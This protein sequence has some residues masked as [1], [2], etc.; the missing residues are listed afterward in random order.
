MDSNEQRDNEKTDYTMKNEDG[1][2]SSIRLDKFVSDIL[3]KN[4]HDVHKWLQE[5][6]DRVCEESP[7]LSRRAKGDKVRLQAYAEVGISP[8]S[9]F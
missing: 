4:G 7:H 5:K 2:P 8:P 6:Y 1:S 9:D 3:H